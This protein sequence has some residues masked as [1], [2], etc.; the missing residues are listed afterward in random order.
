MKAMIFAAG[1]GS[2]LGP[3][4]SE[5]PK[6]LVEINDT[7]I[8]HILLSKLIGSG[9]NEIIINIHH[10]ADMIRKSLDSFSSSGARIEF[11]DETDELLE[12][13]GG[14]KKAAWFFDDNKPF[15]LHNADILSGINLKELYK[16]HTA[17][18]PL[19][20]L[21]V[22]RRKS[23]RY[24]LFDD[25]SMLHGW[26]NTSTGKVKPEGIQPSN[27]QSYAFS[28]IHVA[29]HELLELIIEEGKFSLTDVYLRLCR[30][31]PIKGFV[32]PEAGWYDIGK[33]ESLEKARKNYNPENPLN[34]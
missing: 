4:T 7:P 12:T 30:T 23:G 2:R 26:R 11:S 16:T 28:G 9:F 17:S 32:H 15:L 1:I 8:L 27:Y 21:A 33:P 22:S 31:H 29:G 18:N 3:V 13:G 25:K 20:T 14:L 6:A 10:K 5:I 24:L 19:A 34:Q